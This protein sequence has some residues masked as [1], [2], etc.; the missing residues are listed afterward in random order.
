MCFCVC[1]R[2]CLWRVQWGQPSLRSEEACRNVPCLWR[3]CCLRSTNIRSRMKGMWL[4]KA[5]SSPVLLRDSFAFSSCCLCCCGG[6]RRAHTYWWGE[7]GSRPELK[8]TFAFIWN[9]QTR[10]TASRMRG[11][12]MRGLWVKCAFYWGCF[13]LVKL[14]PQIELRKDFCSGTHLYSCCCPLKQDAPKD[15][16][17]AQWLDWHSGNW[18]VTSVNFPDLQHRGSLFN[19]FLPLIPLSLLSSLRP[20][21]SALTPDSASH[22]PRHQYWVLFIVAAL[23][24]R[25]K[26]YSLTV[27]IDFSGL[28]SGKHSFKPLLLY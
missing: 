16:T 12:T 13:L 25:L 26:Q 1:V 4:H 18:L 27:A 5:P 11:I 6:M 7:L 23:F 17:W 9:T 15:N 24:P 14:C 8:E 28:C 10:Q 21:S 2:V 3:V 20:S 22:R 19:L